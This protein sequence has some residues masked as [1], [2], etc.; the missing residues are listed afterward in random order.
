MKRFLVAPVAALAALS[1]LLTPTHAP[2]RAWATSA[3]IAAGR[4]HITINLRRERLRAWD[5]HKVV[6]STP[7]TT[8]D[9]YLPTP[10]G[11][12]TV[13]AKFSPYTMISP[14]PQGDYRWYPPSRMSFAM[15]FQRGYF[16]HDAPWRS[17]YGKGSNGGTQPGTN[18]GGSH[19]CVNVPYN[20]ERFLYF[21]A[22][23][24]TPVHVVP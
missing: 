9:R 16:I 3:S 6:F 12:F 23:I 7:V 21:W 10:T 14:W 4:K 2:T 17:V 5:G 15:E 11:H 13:Y 19:G 20:A 22:P 24:G 8:G 1:V 18:Y